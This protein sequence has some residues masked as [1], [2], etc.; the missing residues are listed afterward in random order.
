MPQ[1]QRNFGI[2]DFHNHHVP[3]HFDLTALKFAPA[4]QRARWEAIARKLS[5]EELLVKDVRDGAL[6]AR[7]VNIPAQ[8]IADAEGW[9]S[10]ITSPASSRAIPAT[11][12]GWRRLTPMTATEQGA[13]PSVPSANLDCAASLSIAPAATF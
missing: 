1:A 5:D 12:T 4:S 13:K 2:I 9:Q 8:L 6:S 3:A 11:S 7:V 10:T